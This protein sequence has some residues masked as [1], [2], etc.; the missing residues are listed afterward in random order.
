MLSYKK[1]GVTAIAHV[2]MK[3]R[4]KLNWEVTPVKKPSG[5]IATASLIL[6]NTFK[7]LSMQI[8][9]VATVNA[10]SFPA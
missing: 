4:G 10:L 9:A 7:L 1:D 5:P 8:N 2:A 3:Q 6:R